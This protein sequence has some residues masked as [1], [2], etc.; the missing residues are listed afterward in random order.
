MGTINRRVAAYFPPDLDKRFQEYG[1]RSGLK[2]DSKILIHMI[3][4]FLEAH[5]LGKECDRISAI[6]RDLN[7]MK[8]KIKKLEF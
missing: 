1:D 2:G 5:D 4:S 3:E 6:E 7:L 8:E